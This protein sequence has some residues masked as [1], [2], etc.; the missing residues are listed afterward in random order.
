MFLF[1]MVFCIQICV[2]II[3]EDKN[4]SIFINDNWNARIWK[5]KYEKV[6]TCFKTF[7]TQKKLSHHQKLKF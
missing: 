2:G 4:S 6:S 7:S 3:W 5:E 1:N